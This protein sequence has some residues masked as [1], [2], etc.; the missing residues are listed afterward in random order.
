MNR[1][2]LSSNSEKKTFLAMWFGVNLLRKHWPYYVT[3]NLG[4][5]RE[6]LKMCESQGPP[7][8]IFL[9]FTVYI[10]C[11]YI[12]YQSFKCMKILEK[13]LFFRTTEFRSAVVERR[14]GVSH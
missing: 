5:W 3:F 13:Y 7:V 1:L 2:S 8:Y 6:F 4:Y 14:L 11:N 9:L 10:S 12:I